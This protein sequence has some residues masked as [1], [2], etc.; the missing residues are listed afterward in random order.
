MINDGGEF[1]ALIEEA[2]VLARELGVIKRG[3]VQARFDVGYGRA[4]RI[5][6]QLVSLGVLVAL[7]HPVTVYSLTPDAPSAPVIGRGD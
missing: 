3:D 5:L 2:A 6:D 7:D 4:A 1:D